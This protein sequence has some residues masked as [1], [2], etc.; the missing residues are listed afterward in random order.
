MKIYLD[1]CHIQSLVN[2][3]NKK[4]DAL[5]KAFKDG[6]LELIYSWICLSE[7]LERNDKD[8]IYQIASL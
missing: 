3:E 4:L 8:S 5:R 1:T 2:L 6:K 7:L